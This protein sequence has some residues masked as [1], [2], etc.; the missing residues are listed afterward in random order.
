MKIDGSIV[1]NARIMVVGCGALGN[2]VLKN[3]VLSGVKHLTLVDFDTVE[4]SNL[5]RSVFFRRED[6]ANRCLKVDVLA[7]RLRE[8]APDIEIRTIAGDI[9]FDVGLGRIGAM[10]AVVS[11][12]DSRWARFMINRHCNRTGRPWVE[13]GI[14]VWEGSARVF[15]PGRNCYACALDENAISDIRRRMP[16]ANVVR[17]AVER[18]SVP[19]SS[20]TASII[21][22]VMAQEALKLVCGQESMCGRMFTYEGDVVR[23]AVAEFSAWDEECPEHEMWSG[24][25]Q[26][27]FTASTPVGQLLDFYGPEAALVMRDD[28]FVDYVVSRGDNSRYDVMLPAR[29]VADALA[30]NDATCTLTASDC[31]QNEYRTIDA[32]FPYRNL[33][34]GDLGIPEEDILDIRIAGRRMFV[35]MEE[36]P[37]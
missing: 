30:L 29:K 37:W 1:G 13:G 8:L 34:L 9:A 14:T 6:A 17:K 26:S 16:C 22:A 32:D 12:V 21:G 11:C 4:E 18:G 25:E 3:L 15:I 20:I 7:G 27:R 5:T 35:K 36:K 33:S 31:Y 19:T 23:S 10:D 24:V 2:E 28:C